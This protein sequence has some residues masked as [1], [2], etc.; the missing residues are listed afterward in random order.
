M[1]IAFQPA[2]AGSSPA[3]SN[4]GQSS[5]A[6]G[7]PTDNKTVFLQLLVT[8]LKNQDPMNPVQGT[9][10]VT[11]L[12]QFQQLEQSIVSGQDVSAIHADLDQIGALLQ[13]QSTGGTHNAGRA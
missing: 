4:A 3:S 8:E 1:S 11:Q 7:A 9:D 5:T 10:F 2:I 12:A 6:G 13:N